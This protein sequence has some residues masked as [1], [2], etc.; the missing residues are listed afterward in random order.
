VRAPPLAQALRPQPATKAP[1]TNQADQATTSRRLLREVFH[2]DFPVDRHPSPEASALHASFM[3]W[4]PWVIAAP[5][6]S[7]AAT[8]TASAISCSE[9]PVSR[10]FL[11]WI[12]MQ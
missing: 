10:A 12:S 11:A 4:V 6:R 5:A 3:A 8:T 2:F 1:A 9:A 7:A